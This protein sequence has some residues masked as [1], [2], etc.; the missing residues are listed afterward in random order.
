MRS[1]PAEPSIPPS[2]APMLGARRDG[3]AGVDS[4]RGL[5]MT[6]LGEFVMPDGGSVWTQ[7]LVAALALLDVRDKAA[8]QALARMEDR[9][10]LARTRV[11]RQTR[12]NLT[13]RSRALLESGAERIY[14]FGREPRSWDQR[15]L[16]LLASIPDTDRTARYR[17]TQGLSW[18]G[19]GSLGQGVWISPWVDR[20][21]TVVQLMHELGIEATV[22]RAEIGAMGS[23][24]ALAAQAWDV[25]ALHAEYEE[26]LLESKRVSQN[27]HRGADATRYLAALV[28][29]WRRF[30][31]LDPDL[32]DELLPDDWPGRAAAEAFAATRRR[33]LPAAWDWWRA[34]ETAYA[35]G[36]WRADV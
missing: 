4:S 16:V 34:S 15:W 17:M 12:W 23:G 5:L 26:F 31:L 24:G 18:A 20:E 27:P 30:P 1:M 32:P 36:G 28:H 29:R 14:A 35:P 9:G 8:R 6:L 3:A 25:L 33:L 11:G 10:W 22:F 2:L 21:Q 19:F 7:T 13:D